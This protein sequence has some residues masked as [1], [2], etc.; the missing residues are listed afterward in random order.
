MK[1]YLKQHRGWVLLHI[2]MLTIW[3]A[4]MVG[5]A[6]VFQALTEAATGNDL[7]R[8]KW[9][10]VFALVYL[11]IDALF[12]YIPRYTRAQVTQR[13]LETMRGEL[14]AGMMSEKL[15]VLMATDDSEYVNQLTT[16]L[17]TIENDYLKPLST[18]VHGLLVF[19]FSLAAALTL[20]SSLTLI[21]LVVSC[22]PFLAPVINRKVLAG[23]KQAAQ[24]A[25]KDYVAKFTEFAANLPVLRLA[26]AGSVFVGKLTGAS[27]V[28]RRKTVDFEQAQ[29]M[30]YAI[31][32]GLSNLLYSGSWIVG[33]FFVFQDKMT[34]PELIAMTTLMSMIAGPIQ[35]LSDQFSEITASQGIVNEFIAALPTPETGTGGQRRLQGPIRQLVLE[36]V[37]FQHGQQPLFAHLTQS[38]EKGQRYAI[39]GESGA[40][41]STLLKL[42][43]GVYPPQ[44]GLV[45]VNGESL[46][47]VTAADYY[48]NVAYVPQKTAIFTGTVAENVSFFEKQPDRERITA[49]L[50]Q[51]GLG[52]WL[53]GL[54]EG[55]DSPLDAAHQLSG[56]QERRLDIARALYRN[57]DLVI[58][59]EPTT[60]LDAVNEAAVGEALSQ[61]RD[62]IVIV[63][64]HNTDAAFLDGFHQVLQLADGRLQPVSS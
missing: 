2:L 17:N 15:A 55:L 33:G 35:T 4:I 30:T 21:L 9:V 18:L 50:A 28:T 51:V 61:I 25:K 47:S 10:A 1:K 39:L 49:A 63:V 41:K 20:Q 42:L 24:Q 31:S 8:F 11:I 14:V 12:D 64:T 3:A 58:C 16:D 53:K 7:D 38:F 52:A 19:G 40:G 48:R 62:G 26:E 32:Y 13:V 60:G 34:L 29:G 56:G 5:M 54:P 57:A 36:N 44:A 37:G 46:P 27:T 45:L 43:L 23:K 59:D 6:L 22:I